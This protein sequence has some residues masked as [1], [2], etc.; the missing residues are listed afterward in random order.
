LIEV[1]NYQHKFKDQWD[2]LVR[3]GKNSSFLFY[4]NFMEYHSDRFKDY[5]LVIRDEKETIALMPANISGT[6][7]FSHQGLTYGGFVFRRDIKFTKAMEVFY[8]TLKYLN[9]NGIE[10]L[11]L[12]PIPR[13]YNSLPAD[14]LDW[15]LTICKADLYRRDTTLTINNSD[16]LPFQTRRLRAITKAGKLKPDIKTDNSPD[17]FHKFWNHVLVPNLW[18]RHR[19]TPVHTA[20]EIIKLAARFPDN[21][22]QHNIYIKNE[23]VAGTTFFLNPNV[24]HAQYIG[25]T[26]AGKDT[27]ALDYLFHHLINLE[28]N[29]YRYVDFGNCNEEN[30]TVV[31]YGLMEWKEGFGA[32]AVSHDFYVVKIK[33]GHL[34]NGKF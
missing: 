14:E 33:N 10:E 21:I 26:D 16:R 20:D 24:A 15:A 12:K 4:R 13:I 5:S 3:V 25:A 18:N 29:H 23:I 11:W 32:R 31:N 6:I 34:L 27:G 9:K 2:Q 19:L 30:G 8:Q 7:V 22:R 17:E 28:Y 1:V